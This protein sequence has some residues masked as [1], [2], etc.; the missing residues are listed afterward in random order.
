M[1]KT[2]LIT[3]ML[4]MFSSAAEAHPTCYSE[5]VFQPGYWQTQHQNTLHERQTWI[6]GYWIKKRVCPPPPQ[7]TTPVRVYVPR[8]FPHVNIITNRSHG[9]HSSYSSHRSHRSHGSHS[10]HSSHGS[11][12]S[13]QRSHNSHNH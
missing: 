8:V 10:S 7:R 12:S 2:L 11:R 4:A 1:I 3:T 6:D 5:T 13:S 9:H